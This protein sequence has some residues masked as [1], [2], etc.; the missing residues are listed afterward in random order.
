MHLQMLLLLLSIFYSTI[1]VVGKYAL[2]H[3]T[4][5]FLTGSRMLLAGCVLLVFQCFWDPKALRLE[6]K[7]LLPIVIIALT[8]VYLT[9]ILEFWG[10]QFMPSA[11]ACFLC[12]F[13]PIATALLSYQ[14]FEERLST[15]QWI[16]LLVGMIGFI[17]LLLNT[18]DPKTLLSFALPEWAVLGSAACS[19][20]GW[21]A[22]RT[23]V[24]KQGFSA[25]SA[26]SLSMILGGFFALLHSWHLEGW[27]PLPL[28]SWTLFL[29]WLLL[30]SLISNIICYNLHA[31]LLKYFS[32][33]Y[34]SLTF[35][36]QPFLAALF[37]W[38]FLDEI[39]S[40][41]F[42]ISLALVTLGLYLY[43]REALKQKDT[44]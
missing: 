36:S 35:L 3:S 31:N 10:L 8:G 22:M 11:K 6:K 17:P 4:P 14:W 16:G 30:I 38:I 44:A 1:F 41:H 2:A 37:G 25:L 32:A 7:H 23:L 15:R 26:N 19:A 18:D 29:P 12:G 5:A 27:D 13:F 43:Y 34:V 24:K 40:M 9:N 28:S 39:L 20:V 42:W 21:I 33:T